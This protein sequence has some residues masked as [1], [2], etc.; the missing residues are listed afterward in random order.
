MSIDIPST[1]I[2]IFAFM[3]LRGPVTMKNPEIMYMITEECESPR[4]GVAL[5]SCA[6]IAII[7]RRYPSRCRCG[8]NV[9]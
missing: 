3:G 6:D 9:L 7:Y 8:E 5:L 2:E 4:T 1:L